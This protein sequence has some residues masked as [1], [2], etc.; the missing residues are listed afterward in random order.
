MALRR[1]YGEGNEIQSVERAIAMK[2]NK[3]K[4]NKKHLSASRLANTSELSIRDA[5]IYD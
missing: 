1:V 2:I 4:H 3:S 5:S